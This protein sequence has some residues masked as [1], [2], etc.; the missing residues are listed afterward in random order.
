MLTPQ[1]LGLTKAAYSVK[2]TET[3]LSLSHTTVYELIKNNKLRATK[4][5]TKTLILSADIADFLT[6]LRAEAGGA[7]HVM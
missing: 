4:L 1:E 3:L 2:E 5:N 6:S 7:G